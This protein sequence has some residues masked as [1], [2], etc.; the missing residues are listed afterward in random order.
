MH[1]ISFLILATFYR[2]AYTSLINLGATVTVNGVYYFVHPKQVAVLPLS[3]SHNQGLVDFVPVT[4][5]EA[6]D[7]RFDESTLSDTIKTWLA[8]D[9]V[10]NE[11]FLQDIYVKKDSDGVPGLPIYQY[12]GNASL[13]W[14][15]INYS[16][17]APNGPYILNPSTGS[18]H[19]PYRLYVDT[20]GAFTQGV[21]PLSSGSFAPLPAALPGSSTITIGV[22]SRIYYTPCDK[23]PLAGVRIGVKDIY[24]VHGLKTGA[25]SRAY[26]DLY[27]EANGTAPAVQYL[28]D[29]GAI[30]VGKMKT[31]QFAA[32][33]N[34]RD[35]I[36]YQAPFNPRGDGYQEVGSSSSGAGAGIASYH[37]L[38]LALGSDTGGSIRVPAEDN[39]IFGNRPTHGS[40]D[41]S[42]VIPLGSEFD[43]AGFLAR[44]T[45]IW[46]TACRVM[47]SNLTTNYTRYP[48]RVLTYDLPAV[49][50]EDLSD[51][52][53]VIVQ[54]VDKLVEFLSADLA[55][56]N[57]TDEWSRSNPAATPSDL[58]EFVGSTWVVISAK[59][60]TRLVRDPF[61]K[62][63]A[64]A[65]DGRVPF[66]NPSTNGSW[67]WS[68]T[69]PPLLDEAVANK[70]IFKTWWD[71]DKL[72]RIFGS[73]TG[74]S[75]AQVNFVMGKGEFDVD[76]SITNAEEVLSFVS[77]ASGFMLS[78]I[79]GRN[80]YLDVLA[81]SSQS[82]GLI[83]NPPQGV[84]DVQSLDKKTV[85]LSYE[86]TTIGARDLL[87]SVKDK[88]NGLA[89]PRGD[90]QLENSRRRLWD[91][92]TKTFLAAAL[93]IP[94]A[95]V[96]WSENLVDKKTEGIVSLILGTLVQCIAIPEFYRPA[97]SAVWYS[98][99]V[100]MDMLVVISITAAYV[101]S[102]VAFSFE[103]AGKPL[104]EGQ[105]FETS[106][107]LIT[108]ILVGRLIAAFARV[109]AVSAVSLRSKQNNIA[110][111]VEKEGDREID[112]RLL[113]YG[114]VFKVLP[115]SRVAT[116][117]VVLSGKT[118]VD[119]SMLTGETL[120]IVK[121]KGSDLIAGTV[122]GDG[123]V[124][125]QLT[126]LPGKNTVTDIAQ[127]VEEAAKSR[128]E[129]QDLANKVAG[130]FV[131]AMA[132]VAI[133]VL[134]I[135]IACGMEVLDYDT[136]KSVGDAITYAVATLAVACPCALGLAVPM[137]L[138]VAGGIA[139]RGGVIIKSADTTEG[140]RKTTDVV[141]DK[142]GTITE[143]EL[144][145]TEQV[146]LN[147]D[148]ADNLALAKALVSGG[149]HPVSAAVE[150][151]LEDQ[152]IKVML[153]VVNV[154]VVPGA[155]VEADYL[156]ST[157]RAGNAR[158][159]GADKLD[160][161][162]RLQHGG[163]TTLVVTRDSVPLIVFGL[164][165]QI[166]PEAVRVIS[167]LKSRNI[168]VHLV[169]G[170]QI[171]AVQAVATSVGIPP[172]N[173][174]G[175]R[176][177]PEKRD[178]VASLMDQGKK[179]LFCGDGTNDAIAVAQANV[180]AQ[181]GGG[182]TSSDVTQGAADV[183]LLNGL[184]GIP[185]LLDISKVSFQRMYFNFVW[186]AVYN[187]L[188]ITMASGA[189][190]EF[191]IPPRYAGLGEMVSVVPVILAANSM[192]FARYFKLKE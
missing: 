113:Q 66:V 35:A 119:E 21:I 136:A 71:A 93:T 70:T 13:S 97:I 174:V 48:K 96:S 108:L 104:D 154:Q 36:D 139:A 99:T 1:A 120:P 38:D 133:L 184:E 117:G 131:P 125:V 100:E 74:V 54:F 67:S 11:G 51:S 129:I 130:W 114:D 23:Y 105:F 49:K 192:F 168:N 122:N 15:E 79:I 165:A 155:G 10:F 186:S 19:T 149:K 30:M 187:I 109:Q 92:L 141:F 102:V 90:P 53:R 176:T 20:Q 75:N 73:M 190:V 128:P 5:F 156:D 124:T 28:L 146:N 110:V 164:S 173:V 44:D 64:A 68:D 162:S 169:S 82:K 32:P 89:E 188:A 88:C 116:D 78:K 180:G 166:R 115:H 144:A 47:Y 80:Y 3:S 4:I 185:F 94:V 7:N 43:T 138:V 52:D 167:E 153:Q 127:L 158:W 9:D 60:Q 161:V 98:R 45:E 55:T 142:T 18:L 145:V 121:Q 106:T 178:Y 33:E 134:V 25:G 191:R 42:R 83:E 123:T 14:Q 171:R 182:L 37:W 59:Q 31:T 183:V 12:Q 26:Y 24:D 84:T 58:R 29:A 107:M 181:M 77:G 81:T 69:L 163:L 179:V 27:P 172:E 103:M 118:D 22:P 40:V 147:G 101:Y 87:E 6:T 62:D 95:V 85:R 159:T 151:H 148:M 112:A 61:F 135:W 157:L 50:S 140:A 56:F 86:P 160:D 111:L 39:G 2:A 170:D 16:F 57:H 189:W 34:A 150:K 137:V 46:A 65:H 91:Q 175:E 152:S 8:K 132:T 76:A 126:R 143:A 72:L 17:N 63:Y 41:L 177:P